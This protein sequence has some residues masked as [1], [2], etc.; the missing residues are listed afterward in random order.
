MRTAS[1]EAGTSKAGLAVRVAVTTTP[2]SRVWS[3]A[4]AR[5]HGGNAASKADAAHLP[6]SSLE[7]GRTPLSS[8]S[9]PSSMRGVEILGHDAAGGGVA[10]V[11]D[12]LGLLVARLHPC[13]SLAGAPVEQARQQDHAGQDRG[14]GDGEGKAETGGAGHEAA[15]GRKSVRAHYYARKPGDRGRR[16]EASCVPRGG[17]SRPRHSRR[18]DA[19]PCPISRTGPSASGRR[20]SP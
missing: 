1:I 10:Q 18:R 3:P 8:I 5:A 11:H 7:I 16:P 13:K 20:G 9:A 4:W 14:R 15:A 17:L 19:T 6:Y 2:C 12:H